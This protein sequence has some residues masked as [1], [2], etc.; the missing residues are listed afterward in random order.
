MKEYS[1]QDL[2]TIVDVS[3]RIENILYVRYQLNT[4]VQLSICGQ[5]LVNLNGSKDD[6]NTARSRLARKLCRAALLL[7]AEIHAS[8]LADGL[9]LQVRQ[10][11]MSDSKS[12][13]LQM[14]HR[15]SLEY[16]APRPLLGMLMAATILSGFTQNHTLIQ[17]MSHSG[18]AQ[19]DSDTSRPRFD[20]GFAPGLGFVI[21][22][23]QTF[24]A[25]Y[26]SADDDAQRVMRK[27]IIG[28]KF[29]SGLQGLLKAI[30]SAWTMRGE[31]HLVVLSVDNIATLLS[32]ASDAMLLQDPIG[33]DDTTP[34]TEEQDDSN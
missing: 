25:E 20:I 5:A 14:L 31:C 3:K 9:P 32:Q 15:V 2:Q 23:R 30:A 29:T 12:E 26:Y 34:D 33:Y 11:I 28:E 4:G 27:L 18:S 17:V 8:A 21:D 6:E 1:T 22:L 10:R 7:E 19:P 13:P 16:I 24:L